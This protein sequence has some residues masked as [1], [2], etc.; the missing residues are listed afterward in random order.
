MWNFLSSTSTTTSTKIP[1]T[2]PIINAPIVS[3]EAQPAVIPT[4][5]ASEAFKHI[6]TSGLPYLIQVKIK[7]SLKNIQLVQLKMVSWKIN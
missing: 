3:T 7:Q 5:P 6:P 1:D 2:A 4:K